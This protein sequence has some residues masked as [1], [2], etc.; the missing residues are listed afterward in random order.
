MALDHFHPIVATWFQGRFGAPTD[1]QARGWAEIASGRDTLIMAPTGSGKTL[2]A[3][4]SGLDGL[5]RRA[6]DGQLDDRVRIVYVSPLKALG[7]DVDRNLQAPLQQIEETA[8]RMGGSCRPSAPRCAPATARPRSA[9]AC[10]AN[11]RTCSSPRPSRSTSWSPP[12]AGA[13]SSSTSRP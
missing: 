9:R 1:A 7:A 3:F 4:L 12:R 6:L 8:P 10:S 5:V 13:P 2:A 11:R